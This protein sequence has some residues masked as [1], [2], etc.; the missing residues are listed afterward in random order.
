MINKNMTTFYIVRHG[1]TDWNVNKIIQGQSDVPLN[2]NGEIQAKNIAKIL[3]NI[4]FDIVFSSD[5]LRAKKT[6]EIIALEKK[7]VI[8]V[9]KLLRERSFGKLEGKPSIHFKQY[10]DK[11]KNLSHEK[12]L[13]HKLDNDIESDEEM[14]NRLLLFLRETAIASRG[15]NVLVVT[16]GGVL[17]VLLI[18]M[19]I[20][21]YEE[22]SNM[23]VEN[24]A[25]IKLDSD[26]IDFFLKDMHGIDKITTETGVI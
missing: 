6:A 19:G 17:R 8:S 2:T 18:H 25:R 16:H 1:E 20:F 13:S 15:K 24:T 23:R 14:V 7:L 21:T 10:F 3:N 11:L 4:K 5:L 22:I 12:R 26:G 9:T